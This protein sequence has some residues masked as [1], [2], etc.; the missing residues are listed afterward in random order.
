MT[1]TTFINHRFSDKLSAGLGFVAGLE[2]EQNSSGQPLTISGS[3]RDANTQKFEQL[4][5][6][7]SLV[8]SPRVTLSSM[9]GV[10]F[11]DAGGTQEVNP[12]FKVNAAWSPRTGTSFFLTA[13]ELTQSSGS[14]AGE[15]FVSTSFNLS[16][17]QRLGSRMNLLLS[18]GY[19]HAAY[20]SILSTPSSPSS[21][22]GNRVDD[23]Y[24]A[25]IGVS[26][27][28]SRGWSASIT[29]V[30]TDNISSADGFTSSLG[31]IAIGV[32]F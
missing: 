10:E 25:Q 6:N 13:N 2:D 32:T 23:L 28:L 9:V 1:S 3:S 27:N 26:L 19:E 20:Q 18:I 7:I 30:Y 4:L 16:A 5:T 22:P 8:P 21:M 12:I 31:Q 11:R 17:S 29:Y 14:T 24:T 15:N